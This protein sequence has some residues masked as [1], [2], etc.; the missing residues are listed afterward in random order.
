MPDLPDYCQNIA[1]SIA[2]PPVLIG[3]VNANIISCAVTLDVNLKS[4]S[5]TLDVNIKSQTNTIDV[6]LKTSAITLAVN[7]TQVKGVD[8]KTPTIAASI[9]ISIENPAI[10]YNAGTDRFKVDVEKIVDVVVTSITGSVTVTGTVTANAGTDLNTS[11]LALESGG[12]L[13][14]LAGKDFATQTTLALM[15]TDVD[16]IPTDPAKESGK[17]TNLD[18]TLT[19]IKDTAGVKKITDDVNI[20]TSGGTNII[21]DK[22]TQE[23]YTSSQR[24]VSND[25]TLSGYLART[26]N[27]RYGKFFPRGCRGYVYQV[28]AYCKDNGSTGGTITIY[29]APYVGAPIIA[30]ADIT[31]EAGGTAA[32]RGAI[33]QIMWNFDSMFISYKS[34]TADMQVA[35]DF[36]TPYDSFASTDAGLTWTY[37]LARTYLRLDMYGIPVGDIPISGRVSLSDRSAYQYAHC[38]AD[39]AVKASAGRIQS[40]TINR[41]TTAGALTIYDS[42]TEGGTVIA[43]IALALNMLP[44]TLFYDVLCPTGIYIGFD[45]TLVADITVSYI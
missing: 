12:N 45:A 7:I 21:I 17:L 5:I 9:P 42:T 14:S 2:I 40:I 8:L 6:N 43:I 20:K 31:V 26:G 32:Y 33:F 13:A 4:S 1:I 22:L 39:T 11:A 3:D 37:S 10:A 41:C 28:T 15:K 29:I 35:R 23:A 44:V 16:K 38:T 30:T 27:N 24:V 19:A 25:G 18:T 36:T 34:S